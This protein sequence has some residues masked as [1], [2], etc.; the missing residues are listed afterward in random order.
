MKDHSDWGEGRKFWGWE[1]SKH[2]PYF[3]KGQEGGSRKLQASH[4]LTSVPRNGMKKI[5]LETISKHK[6]DEKVFGSS[7]H[8]Y[9]KRRLCLTNMIAFHD[10]KADPADKERTTNIGYLDFNNASITV[11]HCLLPDKL[12]KHET[13]KWRLRW[14]ENWLS[15]WPEKF[16]DKQHQIQLEASPSA[17]SQII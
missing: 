7:K 5:I 17:S 4:S 10:E 14:T 16:M 11:S 6:K 12:M 15:C 9:M 3:Q 1:E 8:G 13:H 2:C